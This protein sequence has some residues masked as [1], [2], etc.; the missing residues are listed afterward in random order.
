VSEVR[1]VLTKHDGSL[2]ENGCV[3]WMFDLKGV[4]IIPAEGLGEEEVMEL[5]VE[6][7]G[8]D[9]ERQ[10]DVWQITTAPGDLFSAREALEAKGL[11]IRSA[12]LARLP[13]NTV[14]LE[15]K[16]AQKMLKLL[17]SL[18]DLD[19]VQRVSANFDI[20]DELLQTMEN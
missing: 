9:F 12:E 10:E 4:V 20:P 7:G 6:A 11:E 5:V 15:G 3:A 13:Q 8:E 16:D 19:D 18:E 2:G 14:K 1:H 17:E